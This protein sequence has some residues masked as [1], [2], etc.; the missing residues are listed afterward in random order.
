MR[1]KAWCDNLFLYLKLVK[2]AQDVVGNALDSLYMNENIA[3]K[4]VSMKL[5]IR[6]KKGWGSIL[7]CQ[8][9]VRSAVAD[10]EMGVG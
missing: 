3:H 1:G 9:L 8:V 4:N 5:P 10:P 2:L 6:N 7:L